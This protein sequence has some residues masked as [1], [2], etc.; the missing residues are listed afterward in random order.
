MAAKYPTEVA[1]HS[2]KKQLT[3]NDVAKLPLV[4][5]AILLSLGLILVHHVFD[6]NSSFLASDWHLCVMKAHWFTWTVD[7]M[8][9]IE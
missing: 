2:L 9:V 8:N 3:D 7:M 4:L 6:L 5:L 1:F